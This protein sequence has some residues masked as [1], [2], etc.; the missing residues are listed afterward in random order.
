MIAR[1][2]LSMD[3]YLPAEGRGQLQEQMEA[4]YE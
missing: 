3:F 2:A 4:E 1:T